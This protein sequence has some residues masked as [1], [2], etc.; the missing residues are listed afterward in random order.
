MTLTA[1]PDP[2]QL[3]SATVADVVLVRRPGGAMG[4]R[5]SLRCL[6][7]FRRRHP[8][9]ARRDEPGQGERPDQVAALRVQMGEMAGRAAARK[10]EDD[11]ERRFRRGLAPR[12]RL[13]YDLLRW[14]AINAVPPGTSAATAGDDRHGDATG[15]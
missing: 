6:P 8:A 14:A 13:E 4:W 10:R 2:Y 5:E 3:S 11:E 9:A 7:G 1:A 12:F 15:S